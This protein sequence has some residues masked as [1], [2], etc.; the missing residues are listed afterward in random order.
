MFESMTKQK[1]FQ[2]ST[3]FS[4]NTNLQ[5]FLLHWSKKIMRMKIPAVSQQND[6]IA[7]TGAYWWSTVI[8]LVRNDYDKV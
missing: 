8:L 7:E 5:N 6:T 1:L 2:I 4:K 3:F